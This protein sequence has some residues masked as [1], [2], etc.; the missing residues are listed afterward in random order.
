MRIEDVKQ[1][2]DQS[3]GTRQKELFDYYTGFEVPVNHRAPV[4]LTKAKS[5]T[6]LHIDFMKDMVD[7]KIGYMGQ[8]INPVFNIEDEGKLGVV[9]QKFK[10][11]ARLNA[12]DVK[13]SESLRYATVSGLSHRLCYTEDGQF[14]IK[15]IPGWAVVYEYEHTPFDPDRAYYFYDV[16]DLTGKTVSHC[17]IYGKSDVEYWESAPTDTPATQKQLANK[18]DLTNYR[19]VDTQS[20]NFEEVP[21][22]PIM[23]NDLWQ[24]DFDSSVYAMDQYDA[25]ISD[26]IA[27]VKAMRLAYLIIN[28][29]IYTGVDSDGNKIS[30]ADWMSQTSTINF[31]TTED[32]K[33]AGS[34]QFL[35]KNINDTV[36]E[37]ALNRLRTHIYETSGS[38]DLRELT[39]AERVFSIRAAIMRLE[40]NCSET[41]RFLKQA[42]YKM[43]RLWVYWMNEYENLGID[44][45]DVDWNFQRVFPRDL[46]SESQVIASL[47]NVMQ[48]ED[49]L[50]ELGWQNAS[51]IAKRAEEMVDNYGFITDNQSVEPETQAENN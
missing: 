3:R 50:T 14:K 8:K 12:L 31:G 2:Y 34:A 23:N 26:T 5:H 27:E 25:V 24:S 40:N 37:N 51:E 48:L 21:I 46:Q 7:L 30:L 45:M 32:G 16:V 22:I 43:S 9:K 28:G 11:F 13:N 44:W 47:S 1:Y 49:V 42:L 20:H 19:K 39:N 4:S 35:E 15:D 29:K 36:I 6:N 18:P 38:V 33:P 10:E 17:D 41:E